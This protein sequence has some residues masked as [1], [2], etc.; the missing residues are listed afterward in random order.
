MSQVE[1][2]VNFQ[3]M[4]PK[5]RIFYPNLIINAFIPNRKRSISWKLL[6][7]ASLVKQRAWLRK[8]QIKIQ[9]PMGLVENP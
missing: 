2:Y 5:N 7:P 6:N 8:V 4:L 9:Y 1:N 3:Q